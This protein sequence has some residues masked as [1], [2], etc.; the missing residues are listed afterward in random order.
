MAK[1]AKKSAV[2][3]T[4]SK[5]KTATRGKTASKVKAKSAKVAV[6]NK[7]AGKAKFQTTFGTGVGAGNLRVTEYKL[8]TE[9]SVRSLED[10]VNY[11]IQKGWAPVGGVVLQGTSTFTQ[12]MVRHGN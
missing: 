8:F 5:S 3:K 12:T 11:H 10:Q 6:K 4:S 2:K 1:K 7:E 9:D